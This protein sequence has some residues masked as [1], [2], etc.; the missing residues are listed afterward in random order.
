MMNEA[1]TLQ[2]VEAVEVVAFVGANQDIPEQVMLENPRYQSGLS[3]KI[4]SRNRSREVSDVAS[5]GDDVKEN[6]HVHLTVGCKCKKSSCL[7]KFCECVQNRS[8][9]GLS[10]KC[11]NCGYQPGR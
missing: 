3:L 2:E 7:K 5:S 10:C 11:Y 4:D 8:K 9:C 6:K 1:L